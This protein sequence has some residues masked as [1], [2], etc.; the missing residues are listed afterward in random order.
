MNKNT[1]SYRTIIL[2]LILVVFL[3]ILSSSLP[4]L[5]PRL[6]PTTLAKLV[7]PGRTGRVPEGYYD[8]ECPF[9]EIEDLIAW[10]ENVEWGDSYSEDAFD[11][12]DMAAL[13]EWVVEICGGEAKLVLF[14]G[15]TAGNHIWLRVKT[16]D[17]WLDYETVT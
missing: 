15:G 9:G 1:I 5:P 13:M 10:L 12:S 4:E 17:C 3:L 8:I 7:P 16:E 14:S 6:N 2:P 11:C